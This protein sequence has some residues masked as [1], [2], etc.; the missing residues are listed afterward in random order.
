M[1]LQDRQQVDGR[2][3]ITATKDALRRAM[4]SRLDSGLLPYD[5][6]WVPLSDVKEEVA[7]ERKRARIHAIELIL[8]YGAGF[9]ASGAILALT[10]TLV[11]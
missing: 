3:M 8:L 9:I 4:R 5:G 1:Q 7:R 11:Y 10:W 2:Q 6:R